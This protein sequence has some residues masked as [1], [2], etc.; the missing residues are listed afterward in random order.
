MYRTK[1]EE[2]E[3]YRGIRRGDQQQRGRSLA[4]SSF[5]SSDSEVLRL[6]QAQRSSD[7]KNAE[8]TLVPT[9]EAKRSSFSFK[10]PG[11]SISGRIGGSS[12]L[13]EN[14]REE[15]AMKIWK[16]YESKRR[17]ERAL[18]GRSVCVILGIKQN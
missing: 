4:S 3:E 10:E 14:S 18:R 5:S 1:N 15:T 2:E 17:N 16:P 11:F 8:A 9:H 13:K 12:D 6:T 7:A